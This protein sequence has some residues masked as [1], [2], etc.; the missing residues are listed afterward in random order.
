[1]DLKNYGLKNTK[2]REK[3]L[4]ILEESQDPLTAEEI[5]KLNIDDESNLS[6]VYRTL[7][8]FC[9]KNMLVKEIRNDGKA[10]Y[11][12]KKQDHHHVL[13]CTKCHKKIYLD[14]CP[15]QAIKNEILNETGFLIENHNIEL[16]GI[17]KECIAKL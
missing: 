16:Y 11:S 15:Y 8:S 12:L 4:Q 2:T 5:Y 13:I 7:T 6:T 9:D 10:I 1:M 17:C 3:I 14:K